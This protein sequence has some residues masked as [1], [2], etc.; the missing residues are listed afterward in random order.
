M[1]TDWLIS[2]IP[3][4]KALHILAL[5]L[6][7]GGLMTL[8]LMLSLHDPAISQADYRVIRKGTHLTYTGLVTPAAVVAVIAGTWLVFL[9]Q[10]FVPWLFAKL[11]V[12]VVLLLLHAWIGHIVVRIAEAPGHH[13]PPGPYGPV[14][15]VLACATV[16]LLLVLAKPDLGWIAFPDWLRTPRG[17]Q[18]PFDVPSR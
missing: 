1:V 4:W 17:G 16:I 2:T 10:V 13:T 11:A 5:C 14:L 3:L 18:L 9:R 15:A 8:P 7:C 12:V 6:W